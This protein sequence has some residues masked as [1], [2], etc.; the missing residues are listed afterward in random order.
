V[1]NI[2]QIQQT[3]CPFKVQNRGLTISAFVTI[4][5]TKHLMQADRFPGFSESCFKSIPG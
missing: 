3:I 1:S 5:R 2:K 4:N